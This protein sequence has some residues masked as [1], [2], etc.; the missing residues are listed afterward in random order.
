MIFEL[1][2]E[3]NALPKINK[4]KKKYVHASPFYDSN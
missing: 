2:E 1:P 3:H 4:K